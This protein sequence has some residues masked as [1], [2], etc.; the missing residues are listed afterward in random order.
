MTILSLILLIGAFT[1]F[2]QSSISGAM[3]VEL[4]NVKVHPLKEFAETKD[5]LNFYTLSETE[6]EEIMNHLDNYKRV[7]YTF[8]IRN[9]SRL[10]YS[11]HHR[12]QP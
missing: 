7:R 6:K 4:T 3:E 5:S 10:A 11:V 12:V 9:N 1:V 2:Y 8:E